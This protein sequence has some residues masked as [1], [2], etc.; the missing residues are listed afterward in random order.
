[1]IR[2]VALILLS[3]LFVASK[4]TKTQEHSA[5]G[6]LPL[7]FEMHQKLHGKL[8]S[9]WQEYRSGEAYIPNL[10]DSNTSALDL[11]RSLCFVPDYPVFEPGRTDA[12]LL[13]IL[14]YD[15]ENDYLR[16]HRSLET[17]PNQN[18]PRRRFVLLYNED[19]VFSQSITES[20]LEHAL[21]Q[22]GMTL[23]E[24][25]I[26]LATGTS[27]TETAR[28]NSSLQTRPYTPSKQESVKR[29]LP[30]SKPKTEGQ[31]SR[32]YLVPLALLIAGL[33]VFVRNF[34]RGSR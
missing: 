2:I 10:F 15:L 26:P 9:S 14:G 31:E 27:G 7:A 34:R 16:E 24:V 33:A 28:E 23:S 3:S 5:I 13:A 22:I 8:P 21:Q 18:R 12:R 29:I 11:G 20:R 19:D 32:F 17:F 6:N 4:Q 25:T 30:S 1:M